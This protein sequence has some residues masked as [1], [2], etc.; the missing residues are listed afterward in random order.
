[1]LTILKRRKIMW[2]LNNADGRGDSPKVS[3][4]KTIT[5]FLINAVFFNPR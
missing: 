5:L 1:M 3:F 4:D 2:I